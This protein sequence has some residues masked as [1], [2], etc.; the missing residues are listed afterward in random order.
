M[1]NE[2]PDVSQPYTGSIFRDIKN[3]DING[4]LQIIT[5]VGTPEDVTTIGSE[6]SG[7]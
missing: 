3:N 5:M 2:V 4:S 1:E 6:M 7:N